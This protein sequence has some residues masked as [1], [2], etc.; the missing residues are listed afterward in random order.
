MKIVMKETRCI[1][2]DG[3]RVFDAQKGKIYDVSENCALPLIR[4]GFAER[5]ITDTSDW[6]PLETAINNAVESL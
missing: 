3:W 1:S 5:S 6:V 2:P 4:A